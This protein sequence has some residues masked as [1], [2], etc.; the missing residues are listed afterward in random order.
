M[1]FGQRRRGNRTNGGKLM[2][3][4]QMNELQEKLYGELHFLLGCT[5]LSPEEFK[6]VFTFFISEFDRIMKEECFI[7]NCPQSLLV[8]EE[9]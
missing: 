1:G 4:L 9:S 8:E 7:T 3:H 5:Q 6:S 2:K